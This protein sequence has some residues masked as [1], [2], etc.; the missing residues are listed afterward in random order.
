MI[1]G[2]DFFIELTAVVASPRFD[3]LA[4]VRAS[5]VDNKLNAGAVSAV[6]AELMTSLAI[7]DRI[8]VNVVFRAFARRVAPY[9]PPI[10][11]NNDFPILFIS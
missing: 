11:S 4:A 7:P 9:V 8:S 10:C 5:T 2:V 1:E 3:L 6:S